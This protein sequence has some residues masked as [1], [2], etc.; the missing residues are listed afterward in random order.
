MS[1]QD[2]Q[3]KKLFID[4]EVQGALAR[5][6]VWQWVVF[7]GVAA[8][9]AVALEWLNNPFAPV[10]EVA[11]EAWWT[12]GP[13]LLALVCL[14]PVFVVDTVKISN[15]FVGPVFRLRQAARAVAA[16]QRPAPLKFRDSDFWRGMADDMNVVFDKAASAPATAEEARETASA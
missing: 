8:A 13:L 6:L 7:T 11:A 14:L 2:C 1:K 16:G 4:P 3:R 10:G 5:R 15:R 12:Y 9:L